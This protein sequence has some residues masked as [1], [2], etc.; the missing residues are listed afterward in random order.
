M[1]STTP[2]LPSPPSVRPP[3]VSSSARD[4]AWHPY[5]GLHVIVSV[6]FIFDPVIFVSVIERRRMELRMRMTGKTLLQFSFITR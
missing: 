2:S 5:V 6:Y 1:S 4:F 3:R